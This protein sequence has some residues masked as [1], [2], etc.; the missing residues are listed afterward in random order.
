MV[1]PSEVSF[2]AGVQ[3]DNRS[4]LQFRP[5]INLSWAGKGA[6]WNR[7]FGVGITAQPSPKLQFSLEPRFTKSQT[8]SQYVTASSALPYEPTY[9]SRYIFADLER[10]S[11]SMVTR[12]NWTFTTDLSLELFAQ[13]LLS[14]GDYLQYK[15]L[16]QP[17]SFEFLPFS[18]GSYSGD[19][20]SQAGTCANDG[21]RYL[22]FD[23]D[24]IADTS[25][26]DRDFNVRSLRANA[27][28]RWEYS[29]GSTIFFV[30]QRHQSNTANVGNFDLSRDLSALFDTSADNVFI[31]K[32][33]LWISR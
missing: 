28:L 3:T 8:G 33:N 19:G 20:C 32:A 29:P 9:G 16:A 1:F 10:T 12:L 13:P 18:E 27:V 15:Q 11:L 22:D 7:S 5:N 17:E 25:T 30:W 2:N 14:S 24:G 26:R 4:R 6:G 21:T 23:G 31:L